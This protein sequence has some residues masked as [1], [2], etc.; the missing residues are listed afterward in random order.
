MTTPINSIFEV[1]NQGHF[2]R[3]ALETFRF[4]AESCEVYKSY[5]NLLSVDSNQVTSVQEIPFIPIELFKTHTV[6]G[7]A[8]PPQHLFTSSATTGMS[9]SKHFIADLSIYEESFIRAF[10]LLFG[11]PEHYT[12]LALLPSY[13]ERQDS[14]LIYMVNRLMQLSGATENGFYLYNHQDLYHQLV[15]LRDKGKRTLLFGVSFALLDFIKNYTIDFPELEII[16]TG[17]MKGR[18]VELTRTALHQQI[19]QGL[20]TCHISSEYGMAELLSQSYAKEGKLFTSPPWMRVLIRD[21]HD[22]F[23]FLPNK[24]RGGIN[25]IDLANRYSCAFIQT[26]DLGTLHTNNT[27]ELLGRIPF[28]ELRG[29]NLL[30]LPDACPIA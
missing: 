3:L 17:G 12:I 28:T 26:H 11:A 19:E 20:G 25:I 5:L 1:A 21:L 14:S 22:P 23:R 10:R 8:H 27:F 6:Y 16:E 4:Q 15:S 13:S 7:G 18:G 30:L 24:E 2:N 29:C 9:P